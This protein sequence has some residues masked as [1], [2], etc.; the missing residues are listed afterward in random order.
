MPTLPEAGGYYSD[1]ALVPHGDK[2]LSPL[3]HEAAAGARL[4]DATAALAQKTQ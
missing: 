3:V 4:W 1:C 2:H